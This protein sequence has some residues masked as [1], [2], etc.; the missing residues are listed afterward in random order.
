[1]V[2]PKNKGQAGMGGRGKNKP[3]HRQDQA[4]ARKAR[5]PTLRGE[6]KNKEGAQLTRPA[7]NPRANQKRNQSEWHQARRMRS[8]Y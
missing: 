4:T 3:K 5:P 8:R 7:R 2:Q 6:G 1:M